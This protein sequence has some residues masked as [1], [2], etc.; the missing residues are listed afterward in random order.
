M[1]LSR[2]SVELQW[3]VNEWKRTYG[4]VRASHG[5]W[6]RSTCNKYGDTDD[7]SQSAVKWAQCRRLHRLLSENVVSTDNPSI[8]VTSVLLLLCGLQTSTLNFTVFLYWSWACTAWCVENWDIASVKSWPE[9][10]VNHTIS[11]HTPLFFDLDFFLVFWLL[12]KERNSEALISLIWGYIY[13]QILQDILQMF[14]KHF[15]HQISNWKSF[16]L[17]QIAQLLPHHAEIVV[18]LEST[19][20]LYVGQLLRFCVSWW[21]K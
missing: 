6:N 3:K 19:N 18:P 8:T 14:E 11:N 21:R 20:F 1:E 9:R 12:T 4:C 17:F 13:L 5:W 15:I 10:V 2:H 16:A 7:E